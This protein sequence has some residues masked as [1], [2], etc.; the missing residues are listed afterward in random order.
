MKK[1]G[2]SA[3]SYR[4][5]FDDLLTELDS[6]MKNAGFSGYGDF[7]NDDRTNEFLKQIE[8]VVRYTPGLK[9]LG[10]GCGRRVY[11][12]GEDR[13]VIKVAKNYMGVVQNE[14]EIKVSD[15]FTGYRCFARIYAHDPNMMVMVED[16][17]RNVQMSNWKNL[18]GISLDRMIQVMRIVMERRSS[19]RG[20]SLPD[21]LDECE[22]MENTD[23]RLYSIFSPRPGSIESAWNSAEYDGLISFLKN[24]TAAEDDRSS[25]IW[26]GLSDMFRFYFENGNSSI[27]LDELAWIDQWGLTEDGERLVLVDFGVGSDFESHAQ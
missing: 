11:G 21:F 4:K 25:R 20:Y 7:K 18:T 13:Y 6:Q 14:N 3:P 16:R 8:L 15:T 9:F 17:C 2:C 23:M 24:M 27:T 26:H 1:E 10:E 19:D 12:I 22:C 5:I